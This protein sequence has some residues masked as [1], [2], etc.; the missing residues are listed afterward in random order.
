MTY[1]PEA[2]DAADEIIDELKVQRGLDYTAGREIIAR[3]VSEGLLEGNWDIIIDLSEL[4]LQDLRL[5]NESEYEQHMDEDE[6]R[7]VDGTT[8]AY[9][10]VVTAYLWLL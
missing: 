5:I 2:Y 1:Y 9:I 6:S 8:T 10:A 4:G 7:P 3:E